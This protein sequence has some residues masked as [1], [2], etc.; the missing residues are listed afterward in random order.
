MQLC[1]SV[2]PAHRLIYIIIIPIVPEY[3][4]GKAGCGG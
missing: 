4:P 2:S 1:K 3:T